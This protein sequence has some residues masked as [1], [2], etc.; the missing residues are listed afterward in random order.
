[1]TFVLAG[2]T[3]ASDA[4]YLYYLTQHSMVRFW[5]GVNSLLLG[6]FMLSWSILMMERGG[7]WSAAAIA[8][9]GGLNVAVGLLFFMR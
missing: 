9:I 6:L 7:R 3:I 2:C 8:A 5:S 4:A 1:M